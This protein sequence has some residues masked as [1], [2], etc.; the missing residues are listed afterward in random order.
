MT[1]SAYGWLP[2]GIYESNSTLIIAGV[3]V[4]TGFVNA[5]NMADGANGLLALIGLS[6]LAVLLHNDPASF[7]S[8]FILALLVFFLFN[9]TT[10]RIFLGDFGAYGLSAMIAF[11][12]LELYARGTFSV[13]FL[14]SVLAYPCVEMVRVLVS[15]LI[16]SRP[17]LKSSDDHIHNFLYE[18]LRQKGWSRTVANSST[19]VLLGTVS[20]ILPASLS[21]LGLV[22][23]DNS[24]FWGSYFAIYF[25]LHVEF[26]RQIKNVVYLER[27][28]KMS[29]W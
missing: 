1:V 21:F 22:D 3:L 13:W 26:T 8:L 6:F 16:E 25:I 10:G 5:G 19:G 28:R 11:S 29:K 4:V 7:A 9:I 14:G 18:L 20:S 27:N 24:V 23:V 12:A 17:A 15:R 2:Y